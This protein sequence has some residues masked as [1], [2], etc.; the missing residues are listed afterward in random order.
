MVCVFKF[1]SFHI[2]ATAGSIHFHSKGNIFGVQMDYTRR[3]MKS[4]RLIYKK[5]LSHKLVEAPYWQCS[6]RLFL[7]VVVYAKAH[8]QIRVFCAQ[9]LVLVNI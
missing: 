6:T 9:H 8:S 2:V 1:D 4:M 3:K 5:W 7:G